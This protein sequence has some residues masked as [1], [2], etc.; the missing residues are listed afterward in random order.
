MRNT[1]NLST[2]WATIS[3]TWEICPTEW[4]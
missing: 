3:F 1:G 4:S 2:C